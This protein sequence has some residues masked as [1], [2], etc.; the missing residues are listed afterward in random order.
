MSENL[1]ERYNLT[2]KHRIEKIIKCKFVTRY[3]LTQGQG[4]GSC[5][6]DDKP[7]GRVTA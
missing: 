3:T 7:W 4:A 2:D 1:T 5:K 6:Y